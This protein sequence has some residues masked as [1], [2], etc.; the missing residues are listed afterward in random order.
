MEYV[1]KR[2]LGYAML[3][4]M[5]GRRILDIALDYGYS[6]ERSF[7]RGFQ[8]EFGQLPSNCRGAGYAMP[9]KPVTQRA[10]LSIAWRNSSGL[11][12]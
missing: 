7:S 10:N 12:K 1:R 2:R 9:P 3:D 5:N 4:V 11:F 6:S 8:Q